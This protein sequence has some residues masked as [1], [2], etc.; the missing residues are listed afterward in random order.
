MISMILLF[1]RE[2]NKKRL[3]TAATQTRSIKEEP[4]MAINNAEWKV[5]YSVVVYGFQWLVYVRKHTKDV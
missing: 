4:K 3:L 2:I 5:Q 1:L